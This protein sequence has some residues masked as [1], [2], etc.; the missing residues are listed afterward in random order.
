MDE[1][2]GEH[3][4]QKHPSLNPPWQPGQSGNPSGR[5]RGA[6]NKLGE[7]FLEA[8]QQDFLRG[9]AAA[10]EACRINTPHI[11]IKVIA[12]VLPKEVNINAD[13]AAAFLE[14]LTLLNREAKRSPLTLEAGKIVTYEEN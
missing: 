6:R 8:L 10:I 14:V 5:P 9:G 1:R 11:Y 4:P 12:G 2:S 3:T 13:T 7:A